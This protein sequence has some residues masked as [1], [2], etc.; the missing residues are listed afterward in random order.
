MWLIF[1]GNYGYQ[2]IYVNKN[3]LNPAHIAHL[4]F[5]LLEGHICSLPDVFRSSFPRVTYTAE[6]TKRKPSDAI[7]YTQTASAIYWKFKNR[8]YEKIR[9]S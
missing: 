7:S 4:Y 2:N 3:I 8:R 5:V 9:W 6:N 1:K